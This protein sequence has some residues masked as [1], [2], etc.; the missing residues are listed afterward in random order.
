MEICIGNIWTR[1]ER[2]HVHVQDMAHLSHI[3]SLISR[4]ESGVYI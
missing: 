3:V 2:V 1:L 4:K